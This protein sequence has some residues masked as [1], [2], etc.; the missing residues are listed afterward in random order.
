MTE[1]LTHREA[2]LHLC[3][4]GKLEMCYD[5]RWVTAKGGGIEL[6]PSYIDRRSYYR[7]AVETITCNGVE[8]LKPVS[9]PLEKGQRYWLALPSAVTFSIVLKWSNSEIDHH[10]LRRGLVHLTEAAAVTHARA[11]CGVK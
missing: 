2:A 7:A 1:Y 8:V 9:E 6:S 10:R 11:M 5:E 4:G 3:N